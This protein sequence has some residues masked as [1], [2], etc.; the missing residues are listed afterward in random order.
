MSIRAAL[1]SIDFGLESHSVLLL[2]VSRASF[3][4]ALHLE[5][6]LVGRNGTPVVCAKA[7]RRKSDRNATGSKSAR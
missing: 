2:L 1:D 4:S 6:V 7:N 5:I 3:A